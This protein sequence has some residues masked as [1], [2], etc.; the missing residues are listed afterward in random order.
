MS[1]PNIIFIMSD[2]HAAQAMSCYNSKINKT[3]NID[4]IAEEGMLLENCLCTNSICAPSRATIL[5]GKY[6][7]KNGVATLDDRFDSSQENFAKMLHKDGYQ[8]AM[9]GKWHLGQEKENQPQGFDY[10]NVFPNQ[11][12]YIDPTMIE[13]GER[14]TFAGY[15]TD[16]VT[17]L[18]IDW[19]E[20]RDEDKPFMLMCHHKA[21]HR[22]WVPDEKH[23][24]MY[25]DVDIPTPETFNDDYQNRAQAAEAAKMRIDQDL[26][27][28]WD[29]K[30]IPPEEISRDKEKLKEWKYQ[31]YIKDYLRCIASIDDNVGRIL[32]YLDDN[33]LNNNTIIIYTSDQGFF[34]GEHG[35]FDK[36]FF[37]EE[38]LRMPFVIRYPEEIEAGTVSDSIAINTDFAP[39]FLDYAGL[40]I[41]EDMQ[42]NSLRDIFKSNDPKNWR[43]SMYYHYSMYPSEHNV[44]PH[45]GIRTDRYKLIY[46]YL[47]ET[48]CN[49]L[50]KDKKRP[51]KAEWELFDLKKD[52]NEMNN[53]YD[54]PE[55]NEITI[56][57]KKEL[58]RLKED[59]ED[60][61]VS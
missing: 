4:R 42:G 58:Y 7:H 59:L 2:D 37:Y 24:D 23:A 33:D 61:T 15:A 54:N 55:Y 35:W 50:T 60:F 20:N 46:Y 8:T 52:P 36:R 26:L 6:S 1:K 34:L 44:F 21:P 40:D 41:P 39:T 49:N 17:D 18:S 38:S 48:D 25:S 32:D 13:M 5:T 12:K 19:L 47:E 30:N 53:V 28:G 56:K 31:E 57:L 45:Y 3:P 22:P 27:Y 51:L 43:D 10:W 14:K 9:I 16:I 29:L 11:G